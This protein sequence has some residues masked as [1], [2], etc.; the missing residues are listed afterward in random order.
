[1]NT[2]INEKWGVYICNYAP[3]TKWRR[4]DVIWRKKYEKRAKM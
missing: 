2:E 1:M 4:A 3:S